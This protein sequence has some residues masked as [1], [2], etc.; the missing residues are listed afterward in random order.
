MFKA[1]NYGRNPGSYIIN[2]TCFQ[3]TVQPIN[4]QLSNYEDYLIEGYN[5]K[6]LYVASRIARFYH[7]SFRPAYETLI[8]Y[9]KQYEKCKQSLLYA[10]TSHRLRLIELGIH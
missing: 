8:A 2:D 1:L 6:N 7:Q 5:L 4:I 9:K 3:I 10:Q